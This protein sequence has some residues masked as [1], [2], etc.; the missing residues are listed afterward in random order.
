MLS[1]KIRLVYLE[2]VSMN[3]RMCAIQKE[4]FTKPGEMNREDFHIL[5][6]RK[7]FIW[8]RGDK[9]GTWKKGWWREELCCAGGRRTVFDCRSE[10]VLPSSTRN[11][12]FPSSLFQIYKLK[13][14]KKEMHDRRRITKRIWNK[15]VW[16]MNSKY[17]FLGCWVYIF[18]W[19]WIFSK[20]IL[21]QFIWNVW[22]MGQGNEYGSWR[23]GL[24][25]GYGKAHENQSL[26]WLFVNLSEKHFRKK[27]ERWE[28]WCFLDWK[29]GREWEK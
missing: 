1:G 5:S 27:W 28:W 24:M 2:R 9:C 7:R 13:K 11:A 4:E 12:D 8:G 21:R 29:P 23:F 22:Y 17:R 18:V 10:L 20:S 16:R 26:S 14:C 19:S 3:C 25:R 6:A 15:N